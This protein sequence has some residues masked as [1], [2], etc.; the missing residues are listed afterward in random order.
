MDIEEFFQEIDPDLLKY[1]PHF[2]KCGFS[3]SV[4]MKYWREQDFQNLQVEVPEGHR[5]LILNMVSKIRTPELKSGENRSSLK[6]IEGRVDEN[7][8]KSSLYSRRDISVAFHKNERE[9]CQTLSS[10]TQSQNKISLPRKLDLL[11]PVERYIKSKKDE[12]EAK[13]EEIERKKEEVKIMLARIKE[14]ASLTGRAGQRC[15]NCHQKNHTVRSCIEEKCGSSFLCGDLSKHSDEK[16]AVQEKKR[17]IATLETSVKKIA[18][19]LTARQ[20]ALSGVANSVNKHFEDILMEEFPDEYM[21]NGTRSWLKI[22]QDVAF[23]KKNFKSGT[24]P[25]RDMGV[26]KTSNAVTSNE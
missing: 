22:Q 7:L 13:N 8:G 20:A 18:Q 9:P 1:A 12:L 23:I 19:D 17:V 16:L 10:I 24:L 25:S 3:S 15:S 4:T 6:P 14:A 2:R 26:S 21:E 11:S 5:R